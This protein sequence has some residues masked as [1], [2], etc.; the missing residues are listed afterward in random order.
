MCAIMRCDPTRPFIFSDGAEVQNAAEWIKH[1]VELANRTIIRKET[2]NS[3]SLLL[4]LAAW[5]RLKTHGQPE[6]AERVEQLRQSPPGHPARG[7]DLSA[8]AEPALM[9]LCPG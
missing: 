9:S 7:A 4:Q 3:T 8:A 5:L 6:M 1:A 2:F